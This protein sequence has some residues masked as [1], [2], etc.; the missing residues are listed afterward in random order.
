MLVLSSLLLPMSF[1][2]SSSERDT[3]SRGGSWLRRRHSWSCFQLTV[4]ELN[5]SLHRKADGNGDDKQM[6]RERG[7]EQKERVRCS[8]FAS[9]AKVARFMGKTIM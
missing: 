4:I 5:T 7:V 9:T 8:C 2:G 6:K 3:R 1:A